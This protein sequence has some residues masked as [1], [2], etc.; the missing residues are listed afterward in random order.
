MSD[1]ENREITEVEPRDSE[2][3]NSAVFAGILLEEA[4]GIDPDRYKPCYWNDKQ[5]SNGAYI[6]TASGQLRC[7]D[8]DWV[9]V[10]KFC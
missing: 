4:T 10:S 2:K 7:A 9:Y 6:C 1:E 5:Y 8:G 3:K